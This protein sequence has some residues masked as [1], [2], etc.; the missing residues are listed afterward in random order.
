MHF[1]KCILSLALFIL[2]IR[3]NAALSEM[4]RT[5][6]V[7]VERLMLQL[8]PIFHSTQLRR[9]QHVTVDAKGSKSWRP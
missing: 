6:S 7:Q 3:H 5:K 8:R 9:R 4:A 2:M 1:G